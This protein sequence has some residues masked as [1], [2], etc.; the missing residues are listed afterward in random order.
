MKTKNLYILNPT[1][2]TGGTNNLLYNFSVLI[3]K[4][5]K[6]KVH[7]LD[8]YDSPFFKFSEKPNFLKTIIIDKKKK[9]EI[10]DGLII[11]ILLR[12]KNLNNFVKFT[13]NTRFIFW[14]THPDDG[15]KLL[16]SF[17]LWMRLPLNY[18]K[19]LAS[20]FHYSRK[21]KISKILDFGSVN[22][23]I[24]W[25]DELNYQS[26]KEFYDLK[27][28][29]E[30][31]PVITNEP[32]RKMIGILRKNKIRLVILGR[33]NDFKVNTLLPLI[34]QIKYF[35]R[36]NP[37]ISLTIDFIG[38][39]TLKS[40]LIDCLIQNNIKNYR[41]LGHIDKSELDVL[42]V[43]YDMLIGMATSVL[44]GAK[45]FIPSAIIDFSFNKTSPNKLKMQWLYESKPYSIG[46]ILKKKF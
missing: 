8:Y 46:R 17:N 32:K 16:S 1:Y 11:T 42:L 28:Y 39:G 41:F 19:L 38:D 4:N 20:F 2:K 36:S 5:P 44:E 12:I 29:P 14:S 31:W 6:Y 13:E 37:D 27:A 9:V 34:S 3:S 18:S 24:V 26:N 33:L 45:L 30:I 10:N 23:G 43:K 15:R 7:Y 21:K 35:N 25:M 40:I 22:H